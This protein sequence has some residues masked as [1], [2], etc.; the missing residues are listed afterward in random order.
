V[1]LVVYEYV[2]DFNVLIHTLKLFIHIQTYVCVCVRA[3]TPTRRAGV[4]HTKWVGRLDAINTFVIFPEHNVG[5]HSARSET[6][7]ETELS[8]LPCNFGGASKGISVSC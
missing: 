2:D 1:Q 7:N 8:I 5:L 3:G 6:R 4:V